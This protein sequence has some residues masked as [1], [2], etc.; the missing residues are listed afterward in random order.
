[1]TAWWTG[2]AIG[3][4]LETDDKDS[5]DARIITACATII[6]LGLRPDVREWVAQPER[7][8]P[9]EATGVHG[10]TTERAA[11]I[12]HDRRE[13]V[14]EIVDVL[15]LAGAER[16]VICHNAPY[17][18]TVLDREMRRTGIGH[19][20][21]ASAGFGSMTGPVC[22]V[23]NGRPVSAFPVID[24]LVLD[25]HL[26]PFR[27]GPVDADGNKLGGRNTLSVAAPL[28]GVTLTAE[29]AHSSTADTRACVQMALAM[30][31]RCHMR[32]PDLVDMYSARRKPH[33]AAQT[34]QALRS[35][36]LDDLHARQV[37]WAAEQAASLAQ[38]ARANPD[39]TDIDPDTVRGDW[40]VRWLKEES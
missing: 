13:V 24:T 12:G 26:D 32:F 4:D 18:L 1:M 8:I 35:V 22:I 5:D 25:K 33:E 15:R 28:Y 27:P 29:D 38:W 40:P 14:E 3:F 11:E 2:H 31:Q 30:A 19:L 37:G 17:D 34:F 23:L 39:K 6:A 36:S 7:D 9:A 16:P 21:S 10:I 20:A